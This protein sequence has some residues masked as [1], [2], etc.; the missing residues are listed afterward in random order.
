MKKTPFGRVREMGCEWDISATRDQ[1]YEWAHR[2]GA[3]WP[4]ATM[5][6]GIWARF[7]NRQG[8]L[9]DLVDTNAGENVDGNEF[10]AWAEDVFN[11]ARGL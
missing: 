7:T 9:G 10:S 2:P 8:A 5:R 3:A 1:L 11:M 4:C 6:R